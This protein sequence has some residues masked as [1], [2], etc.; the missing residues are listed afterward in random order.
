MPPAIPDKIPCDTENQLQREIED[1]RV[2]LD[3]EETE[4]SWE[5]IQRSLARF[6][7]LVRGGAYRH[8]SF[9]PSLRPVS[10]LINP[11][12]LSE[13]GRLSAVAIEL[14]STLAS[15]LGR[16]F[17]PLMLVFAPTLMKLCQRP[18]KVVIT[19]THACITNIIQQT[20][21]PS[22][23]PFLKDALKDKSVTLRVVA[24]ESTNLCMKQIDEER[25][26]PKLSDIEGI[27]KLAGRDANPEVRKNAR[28]LLQEYRDRFPER[29]A[30]F[31]SPLTPVTR[32]NLDL[33]KAAAAGLKGDAPPLRLPLMD[34]NPKQAAPDRVLKSSQ[35]VDRPPA[36]AS[37]KPTLSGPDNQP[38]PSKHP[39]VIAAALPPRPHS[40]ASIRPKVI[41]SQDVPL[42]REFAG[43]SRPVSVHLP[44]EV[45]W[46][47]NQSTQPPKPSGL[48]KMNKR[49]DIQ[50]QLSREDTSK[51]G[52]PPV[53]INFPQSSDNKE[54]ERVLSDSR[55]RP[56]VTSITSEG[57]ASTRALRVASGLGAPR[58]KKDNMSALDHPPRPNSVASDRPTFMRPKGTRSNRVVDSTRDA[59]PISATSDTLE[60]FGSL[61]VE[62]AP[63]KT[64][65]RNEQPATTPFK[66]PEL[67]SI[68][69][70]A[71]VPAP[72][73]GGGFSRPTVVYFPATET[74]VAPRPRAQK[75]WS[76]AYQLELLNKKK[77]QEDGKV[78]A[79]LVVPIHPVVDELAQQKGPDE[80]GQVKIQD[81]GDPLE[82]E[83]PTS[84]VP[85]KALPEPELE[86]PSQSEL[87][88]PTE[89]IKFKRDEIRKDPE[90]IGFPTKEDEKVIPATAPVRKAQGETKPAQAPSNLGSSTRT[91]VV[92]N[93][94]SSGAIRAQP[95]ARVVSGTSKTALPAKHSRNPSADV[96]DSMK[97]PVKL[98][99]QKPPQSSGFVPKRNL[100]S[101]VTQPTK[102]QE[103]RAQALKNE[104]IASQVSTKSTVLSSSVNGNGSRPPS[105][106]PSRMND[107]GKYNS[108]TT[109]SKTAEVKTTDPIP[110]TIG[111]VAIQTRKP[112]VPIVSS[113]VKTHAAKREA[114]L[115]KVI[116]RMGGQPAPKN[117]NAPKPKVRGMAL[118]HTS[119]KI[120]RAVQENDAARLQSE[121][122]QQLPPVLTG[123]PTITPTP[124]NESN[125]LHFGAPSQAVESSSIHPG[126]GSV[127][128]AT[129]PRDGK[130]EELSLVVELSEGT[131]LT[132][133]SSFAMGDEGHAS[134]R[135]H[136]TEVVSTAAPVKG[137][138]ASGTLV[139]ELKAS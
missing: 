56:V 40:V 25:L 36:P 138:N 88:S 67:Q 129:G 126:T 82:P 10:R 46:L 111:R 15:A 12:M 125:L 33:Q 132:P 86:S 58:N 52:E 109:K 122:M 104:K 38:G 72:T 80:G 54:R 121:T 97:L 70:P 101:S 131:L 102:S 28:I 62:M 47:P 23:I 130:K 76:L 50:R 45:D 44:G 29:Y 30:I 7:S 117:V 57:E 73:L 77:K 16:R 137:G 112:P 74:D 18:N 65:L 49:K 94:S 37:G 69:P 51:P 2:S 108:E 19:R 91:R 48:S 124:G 24:S 113:L 63:S 115:S 9:V 107:V 13:R 103:A 133:S 93:T 8:D 135:K 92:S 106:P 14:V 53:P 118:I 64:H 83:N 120:V 3:R 116:V 85:I 89:A 42:S 123:L 99:A 105:R 32:K 128:A 22:L 55:Q 136:L 90:P 110:T 21:L 4:E 87:S 81:K 31:V 60:Q 61:P 66:A 114:G 5:P 59:R 95:R 71:S 119:K 96:K 100:K 98:P 68:P 127:P 34:A 1:L 20:R 11:P 41:S 78:E 6:K 79:D 39:S 26:A 43:P 134:A 27:I 75:T 17:D 35:G 84:S 139:E